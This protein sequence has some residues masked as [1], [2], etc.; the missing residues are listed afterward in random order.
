[1][2]RWDL[3]LLLV[4]TH[5]LAITNFFPVNGISEVVDLSRHDWKHLLFEGTCILLGYSR[6][7]GFFKSQKHFQILLG[8]WSNFVTI[9]TGSRSTAGYSPNPLL[10]SH[11]GGLMKIIIFIYER[12]VIKKILDHLGIFQE[13]EHTRGPPSS[14]KESPER[15]IELYDDGWPEYEEP[16]VVA[17]T[18]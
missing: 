16:S 12:K 5:W 17:Q 6:K 18:L 8:F 13:Q 10:C 11:C 14:P 9:F 7:Y 1:L 15:V 2:V 3:Y 4:R